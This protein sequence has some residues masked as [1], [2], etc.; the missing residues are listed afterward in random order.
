MKEFPLHSLNCSIATSGERVPKNTAIFKHRRNQVTVFRGDRRGNSEAERRIKPRILSNLQQVSSMC[1]TGEWSLVNVK[2]R[3]WIELSEGLIE[4][5]LIKILIQEWEREKKNT[6]HFEIFWE[7][8]KNSAHTTKL[9]RSIWRRWKSET[10]FICR[11]IFIFSLNMKSMAWRRTKGTE[12]TKRTMKRRKVSSLW[13]TGRSNK[14]R[15]GWMFLKTHSLKTYFTSLSSE[16]KFHHSGP[17]ILWSGLC[18][19]K[20]SLL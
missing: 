7:R 10:D 15:Q 20:L 2:R 19:S 14:S 4:I 16:S 5:L 8:P 17:K 13:Y 1:L 9:F 18:S 3:L 11:N 12:S 6:E